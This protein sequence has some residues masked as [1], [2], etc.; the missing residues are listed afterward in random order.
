MREHL[1]PLASQEPGAGT[2]GPPT[3]WTRGTGWT[4]FAALMM[5]VTGSFTLIDGLVSLFRHR[6]YAADSGGL[7]IFNYTAWGWILIIIGSA[8][9]I[10]G[11][12]LSSRAP[13]ARAVAV[14]IVTINMVAQITFLTAY[15]LWSV[16]VILLDA[17]VLWALVVHADD[18]RVT[19]T[20]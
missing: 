17:V 16:I 10:F 11:M 9:I 19:G 3:V 8:Q 5:A 18:D 12:I 1:R 7:I 20:A 14:S 2:S 15:P 4:L 6:V 13:W